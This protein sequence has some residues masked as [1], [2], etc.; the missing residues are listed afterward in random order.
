MISKGTDIYPDTSN[1]HVHVR[2]IYQ[3]VTRPHAMCSNAIFL[4]RANNIEQRARRRG[5]LL[6]CAPQLSQAGPCKSIDAWTGRRV[7][8]G[9][10]N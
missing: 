10:P 4:A 2:R 6:Q 7:G 1:E 9:G 8:T 5:M 3:H